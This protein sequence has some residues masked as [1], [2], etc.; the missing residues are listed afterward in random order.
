MKSS[1]KIFNKPLN[2]L[3]INNLNS[4]NNNKLKKVPPN[5]KKNKAHLNII[6][7]LYSKKKYKQVID[8]LTPFLKKYPKSVDGK[9]LLALSYKQI[10]DF[11]RAINLF[12]SLIVEYPKEGFLSSNLANILYNQ[13]K[14]ALAIEQYKRCIRKFK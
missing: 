13:G 1:D 10:G 2:K 14:I 11:N 6:G 5:T 12:Q 3:K 9:N 7:E 4:P 8:E